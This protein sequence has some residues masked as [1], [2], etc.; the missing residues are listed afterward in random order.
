MTLAHAANERAPSRAEV[1]SVVRA[2]LSA[3][4]SGSEERFVATAHPEL[5]FAFPGSRMDMKGALEV[6]RYWRENYENTRVYV[7]WV[8]VDGTRFAT[9]FQFATTRKRDQKRSAASTVAIG[10][11]RDGKIV[12]F[13]EY[14]DGRVS[15]LQQA[16][17]LPLDE[18]EEPFPWP[19]THNRFPPQPE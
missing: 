15:R 13:K 14:T 9:E 17:Q 10:E 1:E 2:S 16:D 6:F 8:L 5:R 18:G 7:N 12:V 3:W 4:E 19:R 11:V